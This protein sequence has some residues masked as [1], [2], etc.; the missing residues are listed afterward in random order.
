MCDAVYSIHVD[1]G[2]RLPAWLYS[3][4]AERYVTNVV[5]AVRQRTTQPQ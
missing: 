3:R 5:E 2:G 4:A 1:P